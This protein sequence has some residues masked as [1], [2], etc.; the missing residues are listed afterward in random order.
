MEV[1]IGSSM[2]LVS[3]S[4]FKR[5]VPTMSKKRLSPCGIRLRDYQGKAI[6][7]LGSRK[8]RVQRN[9]FH[10]HLQVI[11]VSGSLPNLLGL[12]WFDALGLAVTGINRTGKDKFASLLDEFTDVFSEGPIS[13]NLDPSV[14]PICLKPWRVPLV[15]RP[16]VDQEIDKL[17][18]QGLLEPVNYAKWEMP[19]VIPIKPDGSICICTDYKATLNKAF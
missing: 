18:R 14:A 15:F 5:L 4:T 17:I 11:V 12:D 8:V 1:D 7:I 13:F 6:P 3:W 9:N 10:G 19:I 16:K 2:S